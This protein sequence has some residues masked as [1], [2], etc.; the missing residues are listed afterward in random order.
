MFTK[1]GKSGKILSTLEINKDG[2]ITKE[3]A[4]NKKPGK[5]KLGLSGTT[6]QK[7]KKN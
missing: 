2:E 3:A 6:L 4:I 7:E 1:T 5:E